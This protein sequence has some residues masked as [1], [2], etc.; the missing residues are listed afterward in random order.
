[1]NHGGLFLSCERRLGSSCSRKVKDLSLT[2]KFKCVCDQGGWPS[3]G[4]NGR[5]MDRGSEPDGLWGALFALPPPV[6]HHISSWYWEIAVPHWWGGAKRAG[7]MRDSTSWTRTGTQMWLLHVFRS[8]RCLAAI[9]IPRWRKREA[10]LFGEGWYHRLCSNYKYSNK[11]KL[12]ISA[13]KQ[14][15][16]YIFRAN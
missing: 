1:M 10:C 4:L 12:T 14:H 6:I 13:L 8:S 3:S 5:L 7:R 15:S 9:F 16:E 2:R 11:T